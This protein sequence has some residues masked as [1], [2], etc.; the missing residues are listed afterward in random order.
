M[1]AVDT[2]VVVR[3]LAKDDAKQSAQAGELIRDN[4]IWIPK[5]VLLEAEWVLRSVYS[6]SPGRIINGLRGLSGLPQVVI[7]DSGEVV[8]ALDWFEA[9]MDF[10]DA[11]HLASTVGADRFAT[12]DKRLAATARRVGAGP[13]VLL[14]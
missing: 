2:N 4:L 6:Y 8:Q 12:F 9:G 14:G 7:E 5:S 11:L 3:F 1:L 10:A 13:I